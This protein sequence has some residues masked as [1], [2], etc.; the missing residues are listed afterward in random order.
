VNGELI[1]AYTRAMALDDNMLIAV[2]R[3]LAGQAGIVVP[4]ALTAGAWGAA[5]D[6]PSH[7][8]GLQD[9][10]GR[11]WDVLIVLATGIRRI[12]GQ[13]DRVDFEVYVFHGASHRKTAL[14]A[15]IGPG[16]DG[17]ATITVMLPGE[18]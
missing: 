5:V 16:D 1:Y 3:E 18:D 9:Q 14:Y 2:P 17:E 7:L 11:V 15:Q 13:C 4:V 12:R 10:T 8:T 6:V